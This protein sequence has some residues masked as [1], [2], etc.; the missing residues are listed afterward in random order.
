[1]RRYHGHQKR[2][3]LILT[4]QMIQYL[5]IENLLT[6]YKIRNATQLQVTLM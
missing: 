5:V 2:L 1:M 4:Q 6:L 3:K